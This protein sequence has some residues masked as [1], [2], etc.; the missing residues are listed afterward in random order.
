M[1]NA[2]RIFC[3]LFCCVCLFVVFVNTAIGEE[4]KWENTKSLPANST[5]PSDKSTIT[6]QW[7]STKDL[8]TLPH[9]DANT[10]GDTK[11]IN[12]NPPATASDT[13]GVANEDYKGVIDT[14][15]NAGYGGPKEK[16]KEILYYYPGVRGGNGNRWSF[17]ND[18]I[19]PVYRTDTSALF[20]NPRATFG[21]EGAWDFN[22]GVGYRHLVADSVILG[23]NIYYD[24][25][26][27]YH[28]NSLILKREQRYYGQIGTGV[29]VLTDW[30]NFRANGYLHVSGDAIV[31]DYYR[32]SDLGIYGS[33]GAITEAL[34]GFDGEVGFKIP[35]L[36]NY[37]ETWVYGGGYAFSGEHITN[38]NGYKARLEIIPAGLVRMSVG[39]SNDRID[40]NQLEG[41]LALEIPFSVTNLASGKNPFEG[42]TDRLVGSRPLSER[43]VEPVSRG[44]D[45]KVKTERFNSNSGLV[46]E[47]VFVSE[48]ATFGLGDGTFENPYSTILEAMADPS[49]SGGTVHTI[50]IINDSASGTVEGGGM[51]TVGGLMGLMVWGSGVHHPIYSNIVNMS[52]GYP[53]VAGTL[54]LNTPNL[55]VTG[56]HIDVAGTSGVDI[57]DTTGL[58]IISNIIDVENAGNAYGIYA[59]IG[60][61]F[62]SVSEPVH[63]YNNYI[64]ATSTN[65]GDQAFGMYLVAGGNMFGEIVGNTVNSLSNSNLQTNTAGIYIESWGGNIGYDGA[66]YNPLLISNN[67]VTVSDTGDVYGLLLS[68]PN[69]GTYSTITRNSIYVSN[70]DTSPDD[71]YLFTLGLG[72]RDVLSLHIGSYIDNVPVTFM[73][74]TG[75]IYSENQLN[76]FLQLRSSSDTDDY[77]VTGYDTSPE[78]LGTNTIV[79]NYWHD[80]TGTWAWTIRYT[81]PWNG[82]WVPITTI[83]PIP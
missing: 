18:F 21:N 72:T 57:F 39:Y 20:L 38:V 58:S 13:I 1:K 6:P 14:N 5:P 37:V 50:H 44:I 71:D 25:S 7:N 70:P 73:D 51:I 59:S 80:G 30:V 74:N 2:C 76:Y 81:V 3:F 46:E 56:L 77:L 53:T 47:V 42:M 35:G 43:L 10:V 40:G 52:P 63:I 34:S 49:I 22:I 4:N 8:S 19:L 33:G 29:E 60:G 67:T 68:T 48:S 11:T 75:T 66:T 32:F 9:D 61:D 78:G 16:Q 27:R 83:I 24:T 69:G 41:S 17:T 23:G 55:M 26:M 36:S 15:G 28:E 64:N 62:G 82:H 31:D 79:P 54:I 65:L 12:A 45:M